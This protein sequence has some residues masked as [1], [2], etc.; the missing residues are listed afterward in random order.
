MVYGLFTPIGICNFDVM[1]NLQLINRN[2]CNVDKNPCYPC[3]VD[4]SEGIKT[5]LPDMESI[6]C[7]SN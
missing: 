4:T 3:N 7:F 1:E 5:D 6:Y 2:P